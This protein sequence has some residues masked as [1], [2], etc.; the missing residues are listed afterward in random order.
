MLSLTLFVR[1]LIPAD[2]AA[3]A[4][5]SGR[6]ALHRWLCRARHDAHP[7]ADP[8]IAIADWFGLAG[9]QELPHAA[10]SLLG[11]GIDPERACWLHADP[12]HLHARRTELVLVDAG[13]LHIEPAESQALTES[14]NAHFAQDAVRLHALAPAHWFAEVERPVRLHTVSLSAA[15][16]HS[17]DSLLPR[18]E[19]ALLWHRRSNEAQMLLH[20]HPVNEARE[21]RGAPTINSVWIWGCGSLPVCRTG[22]GA[23]WGGDDFLQG[24]ARRAGVAT[25]V[26]PTDAR[27]WLEQ[28][29]TG[30]HLVA[31]DAPA[32][33][34]DQAWIGPLWSALAENRL[35]SATLVTV[36]HGQR[37]AWRLVRAD[38]WKFWRRDPGLPPSAPATTHA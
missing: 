13:R 20:Q 17:I 32:A 21:A 12:V 34:L 26:L 7:A 18:G 9:V 5:L 37:L 30:E 29:R 3:G 27:A 10:L 38:R 6:P 23:V 2:E 8:E 24:M 19:D 31:L 25:S 11:A 14:L 4:W 15:V 22:F 28:A 36:A 1:A 33:T 35:A 16:G